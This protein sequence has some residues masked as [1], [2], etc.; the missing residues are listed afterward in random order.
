[1][2]VMCSSISGLSGGEWWPM[3]VAEA[4]GEGVVAAGD[5]LGTLA[6]LVVGSI[7]GRELR[8]GARVV[9][10]RR[11]LRHGGDLEP[12]TP[13]VPRART[14]WKATKHKLLGAGVC[15]VCGWAPRQK[16]LLHAH[17]IVPRCHGGTDEPGNLIVLCP[18]HHAEA[19]AVSPRTRQGYFGPK[20]RAALLEALRS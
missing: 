1:M 15:E 18:N 16:R 14:P 20:T 4:L 11:V 17:H 19:H 9:A 13:R 5:P 8:M 2:P 3:E 10:V 12:A 6:R 7:G